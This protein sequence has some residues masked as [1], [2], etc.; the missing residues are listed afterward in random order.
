MIREMEYYDVP[1]YNTIRNSCLDFLHDPTHYTLKESY[2]WFRKKTDPFFMYELDSETIGYFRTSNWTKVSCYVG[3]DIHQDY[4]GQHLAYD[5]Y[6]EFFGFLN[7]EYGT[8]SVSLE[9]LESNERAYNL[10]V[11]LGFKTMDINDR[12]I[13]MKRRI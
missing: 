9:V 1:T 10:Y 7:K 2:V 12:S 11:K 6:I 3:M 8:R 5:A 13:I 4:R